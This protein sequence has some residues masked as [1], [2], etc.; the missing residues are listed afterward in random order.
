MT[1][2]ETTAAGNAVAGSTA[3][4]NAA[5]GTF[6]LRIEI[7]GLCLWVRTAGGQSVTVVMPD[8]GLASSKTAHADGD[9]AVPHVGYLRFNLANLGVSV[10]LGDSQRGP[11]Y[12][13]VH[14]FH[15]EEL[16]FEI[17]GVSLPFDGRDL[18]LPDFNEFAPVLEPMPGLFDK[19]PGGIVLMQTV[20]DGGRVEPMLD[21]GEWL[22]SGRLR[23]DGTPREGQFGG[24]MIWRRQVSGTGMVV[25]LT[26]FGGGTPIA[27]PLVPVDLPGGPA[28]DL[29]IANLCADNPLE[30]PE[31]AVR[32][33]AV[34]D[35]DFKWLY[36][37]LQRRDGADPHR[38]LP[39]VLTVPTPIN[40]E[41]GVEGARYDCF[42]GQITIGP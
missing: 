26:P 1:T 33:V 5:G 27:F 40:N 19:K 36:R 38:Y 15:G 10:P 42:G 18:A 3:A 20:L 41:L 4:G 24:A 28:V 13:V 12:E 8:G 11:T 30:W 34:E 9:P 23:D 32:R 6:E 17:G 25:R 35:R 16:T 37:L 2:N 14:R 39:S 21:S 29:K 31:L 7:S 22:L